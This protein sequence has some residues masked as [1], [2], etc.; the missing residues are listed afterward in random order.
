MD[1]PWAL[2][3]VLAA[4]ASVWLLPT[5]PTLAAAG[6]GAIAAATTKAGVWVVRHERAARRIRARAI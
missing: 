2:V 1:R 4:V 6:L 5:V 3:T